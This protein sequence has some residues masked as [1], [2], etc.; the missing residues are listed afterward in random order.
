MRRR[1]PS[2]LMPMKNGLRIGFC[3][4]AIVLLGALTMP[5]G[6]AEDVDFDTHNDGK[7]STP[8]AAPGDSQSS[9]GEDAASR[10]AGNSDDIDTRISVQPHRP[11]GKPDKVGGGKAKINLPVVANIHRRVF[12]PSGASHQTTHNAIGAAILQHDSSEQRGSERAIA[13]TVAS[14]P[15]AAIFGSAGGTTGGLAKPAGVPE[16]GAILQPNTSPIVSPDTFRRAAI[17]GTS[18]SRR[19]PG[20]SGIGGPAKTAAGIN[21]STIRPTH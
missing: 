19:G 11:T 5:L 2:E 9:P 21:G 15:A 1:R 4:T 16:H 7:A 14:S 17:N 18:M 6:F 12:S 13:P 3:V 10:P 8:A 20:T